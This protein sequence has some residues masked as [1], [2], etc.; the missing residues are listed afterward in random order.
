[1]T[2]SRPTR[3]DRE[4]VS[5]SGLLYTNYR[6]F[7]SVIKRRS[8][9][10]SIF[11]ICPSFRINLCTPKT[12]WSRKQS[13]HRVDWWHRLCKLSLKKP[14]LHAL[15]V[16]RRRRNLP[17][18]NFDALPIPGNLRKIGVWCHSFLNILFELQQWS[19]S[20]STIWPSDIVR[21]R[22]TRSICAVVTA[23][24]RGC[25]IF[26]LLFFGHCFIEDWNM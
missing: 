20:P 9:I 25:E 23:L 15:K 12:I 2:S 7:H 4:E 18:R 14:H 17:S 16:T 1:M 8:R 5:L 22:N 3:S 21:Y 19:K 11:H 10:Y 13:D 24:C 6:H 26:N